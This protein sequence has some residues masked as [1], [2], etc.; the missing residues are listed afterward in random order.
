MLDFFVPG[1]KR[2]VRS[3]NALNAL[4]RSRAGDGS[5]DGTGDGPTF[6][7]VAVGA[8]R[9]ATRRLVRAHGWTIPVAYDSSSAVAAAVRRDGV[10]LIE[11]AAPG[12]IVTRRLIGN[13]WSSGPR[14]R[15][16][17]ARAEHAP[18]PPPPLR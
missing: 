3:V 16:R 14:W 6:A 17:S 8:G 1:A 18:R 11:V 4:A 12:G 2:C 10:P 13:R 15:G 5:P 9:G 7:A